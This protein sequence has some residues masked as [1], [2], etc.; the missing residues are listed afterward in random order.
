MP[1]CSIYTIH[2]NEKHLFIYRT[3]SRNFDVICEL[4]IVS[5]AVP[6]V[7]ALQDKGETFRYEN[8]VYLFI[9]AD[10]EASC[11]TRC[12][13]WLRFLG[14]KGRRNQYGL[15]WNEVSEVNTCLLCVWQ[16]WTSTGAA[17]RRRVVRLRVH[18]VVRRF[19]FP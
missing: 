12:Q 8:A 16:V 4:S 10:T 19:D 14:R 7:H 11:C 1:G 18:I 17:I 6:M 2:M 15:C 13:C 9:L 5:Y 3:S